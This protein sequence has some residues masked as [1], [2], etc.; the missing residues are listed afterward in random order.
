MSGLFE[1]GL[2]GLE[3]R[4]VSVGLGTFKRANEYSIS[5]PVGNRAMIVDSVGLFDVLV[6]S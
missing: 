2:N 1:G 4:C 5:L 3:R 6:D